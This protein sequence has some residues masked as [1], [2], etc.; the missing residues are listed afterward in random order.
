MGKENKREERND[1]VTKNIRLK[2]ERRRRTRTKSNEEE[3][4]RQTRKEERKTGG[5]EFMRKE[6]RGNFW[7]KQYIVEP[8]KIGKEREEE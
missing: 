1:N 8:I 4:D 3:R 2:R 5:R 6:N 7:A